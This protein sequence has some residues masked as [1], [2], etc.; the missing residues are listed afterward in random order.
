MK[1][2]GLWTVHKC[3]VH[4]KKSTFAATVHWTVAALLQQSVKTKKKKKKRKSLKRKTQ[5][6]VDPNCALEGECE[7]I[8]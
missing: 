4:R 7:A 6:N 1:F 5:Q 3:T 2:V 8:Y